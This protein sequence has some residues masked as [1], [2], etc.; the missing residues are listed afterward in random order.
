VAFSP[1]GKAL[2]A[3]EEQGTVVLYGGETFERRLA[4]RGGAV[5]VRG[6]SFSRDGEMLAVAAFTADTVVW[7][8]PRLR[9]SLAEMGLGW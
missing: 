2:A 9:R 1:D 8:L 4:L 7:D 3:G 5:E 6:L